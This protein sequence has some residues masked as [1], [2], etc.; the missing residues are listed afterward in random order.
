[1]SAVVE[2]VESVV[3]AV[4]KYVIQPIADDPLTF[5][6]TVAATYY[7]GPIV[8]ASLGVGANVGAGIAAAAGNTAAGL[9]QGEDFDEAI[10]GGA[11]AGVTTWAGAE[12]TGAGSATPSSTTS[13]Q[14]GIA[15]TADEFAAA[16]TQS[17]DDIFAQA[18]K[19][20]S[21]DYLV[22]SATQGTTSPAGVWNQSVQNA[23]TSLA[24]DTLTK[25]LDDSLFNPIDANIGM[26]GKGPD[27]SL[28]KPSANLP[29]NSY[30]DSSGN[31]IGKDSYGQYTNAPNTPG[32]GVYTGTKISGAGAQRAFDTSANVI[33][34]A[35]NAGA[36]VIDDAARLP[37]SQMPGG[38]L[39]PPSGYD[40]LDEGYGIPK[41]GLTPSPLT[42]SQFGPQIEMLDD[43]AAQPSMWD[44]AL[45]YGKDAYDWVGNNKWT[46]GATLLGL[47][48]LGGKDE[49]PS[50]GG[51]GKNEQIGDPGFYDPMRLYDY[52]R[53][54]IGYGGDITSYGRTGGEHQFFTPTVYTPIEYA[55]G[56]SVAPDKYG[57][58]TYGDI[59]KTMRGFAQGGLSALAKGGNYDG[60]SDDI[61]AVLSDG[62]FVIDAE[63]VALLGNGSSKAGANRLEEMRQAV[64]K[65][66]GGALSRGQ[67]SPDAKSPLAYLKSSKKSRG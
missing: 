42:K 26:A 63:T 61:P 50:G 47:A 25:T 36:S 44:K 45:G 18:A 28:G 7:L 16:G 38:G 33:D 39:K 60:R 6:A 19:S 3:D 48:S 20:S 4:D 34:N 56:G 21:D 66:K 35:A 53:G 1:M 32:Q 15:S 24:D 14:S 67:F 27:I 10:K 23:S 58:Y 30:Y 55:T 40:V 59:P 17:V 22:N 54:Q 29:N 62:E 52:N 31:I 13:F 64:R 46:T 41:N 65:Q 11:L 49:P 5:I 12:L 9:A 43:V 37:G 57:Y 8:G 2:A 51:G